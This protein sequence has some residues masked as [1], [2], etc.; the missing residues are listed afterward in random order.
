MSR[1]SAFLHIFFSLFANRNSLK[2]YYIKHL[3]IYTYIHIY[4]YRE[5]K[6]Y[7]SYF[8]HVT[9]PK[10]KHAVYLFFI[11]YV[12]I[13]GANI[14]PRFCFGFFDFF[15][16]FFF[17]NKCASRKILRSSRGACTNDGRVDFNVR[18]SSLFF[19]RGGPVVIVVA[20][21]VVAA[22]RGDDGRRSNG[23]ILHRCQ[24]SA[25]EAET[26][27]RLVYIRRA[28]RLTQRFLSDFTR[29]S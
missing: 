24:V 9:T 29:K 20:A 8:L 26:P 17:V 4:I 28:E 13:F 21:A 16:F 12:N 22:A 1:V 10:R 27:A 14:I 3:S 7:I 6:K 2:L 18:A 25:S 23:K 11:F 19:V 15:R 5:R